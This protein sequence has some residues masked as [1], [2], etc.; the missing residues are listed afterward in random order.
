MSEYLT[1]QRMFK[2][3]KFEI[4][5]YQ[6]AYSWETPQLKQFVADLLEAREKYYMGHFLFENSGD[7]LLVIDGQQRITT[8]MYCSLGLL[9][10]DDTI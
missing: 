8:C 2:A 7:T 6:R 4:P 5:S 10:I 3:N 1:I 9:T